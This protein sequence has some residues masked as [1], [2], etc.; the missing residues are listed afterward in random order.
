MKKLQSELK[1]LGLDCAIFMTN[2]SP[3]PNLFYFTSYK[4]A[5]FLVIPKDGKSILHV[6]AR[7]LTEARQVKGVNIS[8]GKKLSE[9][10][11]ENGINTKKVG[12]DFANLAVADFNMI[13]EKFGCELIDLTEFM[14]T[15]RAVKTKEEIEKIQKACQITDK[16]ID[17]FVKNFKNFKTE[18]EASAFLVYETRKLGCVESFEPIVASGPNAAVPHHAPKG[19]IHKGFCVIDFGI[20]YEGYCSDVTRTIYYGK[21]SKEE[22][23]TYYDLLEQQEKAISL[24]RP[25]TIIG[26]LCMNAEKDLKQ[27]LIHSLGHGLGIEVHEWPYVSTNSKSILTEGMVITIEPGEYIEGKYGIRIEDDVLVTKSGQK[28]LSR[29]T[30]KLIIIK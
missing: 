23:K 3:N 11:T 28:V 4:G 30:K 8:S 13:K 15:L 21:P 19:K 29:F 14:N 24:V 16:I 12:T 18:E 20:K 10:L 25:A 5:G 1:K 7:D 22:E 27:P 9:A 2:E 17:K 26:D 6:P